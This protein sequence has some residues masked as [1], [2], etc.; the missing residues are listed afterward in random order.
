M[1][2]ETDLKLAGFLTA[3]EVL[4]CP[5]SP[6]LP[7]LIRSGRECSVSDPPLM[8]ASAELTRSSTISAMS[9]FS[10]SSGEAGAA[11][12]FTGEGIESAL[13]ESSSI[14]MV[15]GRP[16]HQSLR[17]HATHTGGWMGGKTY[18]L[19]LGRNNSFG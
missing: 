7:P 8:L 14:L 16:A 3:D 19:G 18:R 6:S 9:L 13:C 2:T 10:S 5:F 15:W 11:A 4:E 1:L 12:P 17:G